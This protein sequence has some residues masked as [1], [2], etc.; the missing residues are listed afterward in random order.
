[1]TNLYPNHYQQAEEFLTSANANR[2]RADQ[3][4]DMLMPRDDDIDKA[5]HLYA[6]AELDMKAAH[7]HAMLAVADMM[8][9]EARA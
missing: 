7:V 2:L 5:R 9:A 8:T 1:M 3:V 4:R 6:D